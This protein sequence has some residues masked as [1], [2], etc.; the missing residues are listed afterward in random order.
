MESNFGQW[1]LQVSVQGLGWDSEV[2]FLDLW[3]KEVSAL[4]WCGEDVMSGTTA[5]S[6]ILRR[7]TQHLRKAMETG[8]LDDVIKPQK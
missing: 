3:Y 2:S 1:D 4:V 8:T 6:V 5:A 7:V